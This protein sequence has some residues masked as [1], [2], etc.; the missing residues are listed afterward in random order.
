MRVALAQMDVVAGDPEGNFLRMEDLV[1]Q[2]K[3]KGCDIVAFPEMC[4]GGYLVGDLWLDDEWCMWLE[5]FNDKVRELSDGI[6]I[7][8]GNVYLMKDKNYVGDDGRRMRFNCAYG[9]QNGHPLRKKEHCPYLPYNIQPKT[10][11]PNYRYFD[12]KRYFSSTIDVLRK[13]YPGY[14]RRDRGLPIS[15]FLVEIK[16]EQK[17][18]GVELCEDMWCKD[19]SYNPTR[20]FEGD[21]DLI[22]NISAS[23]W[24]FG[25]NKARDRRV[26]EVVDWR[27][28]RYTNMQTCPKQV[29][30]YPPFAYVNCVGAQNNG[31]NILCFDGASTV[32]ASDGKPKLT[33]NSSYMEEL[34]VFDPEN[35]P[36]Q[37]IGRGFQDK[38]RQ[39]FWA[40]QRGIQH[41]C[42]TAEIYKFVIG[43]SGGID[44]AVV[45]A[46][47]VKAVGRE[48]VTAINMPSQ[49]NSTKTRDAAE[50]I[51]RNLGIEYRVVQIQSMTAINED[52][53]KVGAGV[54]EVSSLT[55]ENIQAKIRATSLLSNIAAEMGAFF[56]CNGNKDEIALG[57][58]T[59]YGDWGGAIAPISDLTKAEVYQMAQFLNVHVFKKNPIPQNLLPTKLFQFDSSKIKPSAE[60]KDDQTDPIKVGYHCAL[61]EQFLDYMIVTPSTIMGWYKDGILAEKLRVS[62]KLLEV[63]KLNDP[64]V[65]VEDLKWFCKKMR[66]AVFKRVQSVPGIVLSKT[67]WGY[68]RRES[69]L[70]LLQW[71]DVMQT[72]ADQICGND[73]NDKSN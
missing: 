62:P 6:C 72:I 17:K 3:E 68:D 4:V 67:A 63:Y 19:Y 10:L 47:L 57:Y 14:E 60:L 65:F 55:M 41:M 21:T 16:G 56:T 58:A 44:S 61:V 30:A 12:D 28:V 8:Y 64:K 45:A 70:P 46:L 1:K 18:I 66:I 71:T 49:Y 53:V 34:L 5:S 26:A 24:T 37:T 20:E 31:K 32:Y 25:K 39:K 50:R 23:P 52:M 13:C 59:L 29:P 38:I 22:I 2:A 33:A 69:I 43:L 73:G 7:I 15:P 48:N 9:Y 51:A 40:I 35:L 11:L 42:E 54:D 27:K 36:E